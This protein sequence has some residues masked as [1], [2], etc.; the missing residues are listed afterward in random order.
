MRRSI[1]LGG[2]AIGALLSVCLSST[3]A[4]AD[5]DD[6]KIYPLSY[7]ARPMTL[8]ALCLEPEGGVDVTHSVLDPS[9]AVR[10][11]DT[12]LAVSAGAGFG[13]T[14]SLEVRA[15]M[16]SLQIKPDLKYGD[17][18]LGLTFRLFGTTGVEMGI[19][20]QATLFT[21][22]SR[23]LATSFTDPSSLGGLIEPGVPILLRFGKSA[24][25]DL[26]PG[27]MITVQKGE[28]TKIGIEA[29]A[30]LG[31]NFIDM[32]VLGATTNV[33]IPDFKKP[34][35]TLTLPLGLFA[36]LSFGA[37]RPIVE[38]VPSFTWPKFATPGAT[39]GS[40]N[41]VNID[42]FT[43]SLAVRGYIYL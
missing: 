10:N 30:T 23:G 43:A 16:A 18:K 27:A 8:G 34:T 25:L 3:A 39:A 28:A 22:P 13:I 12:N 42:V 21:D 33:V 5:D 41:K 40:Y 32:L 19:R 38:V 14:K 31:I 26:V 24:R 37:D 6:D 36:G 15:T 2:L 1:S 4:R 29:P 7:V 9:S 35:E 11:L 20:A 17:P